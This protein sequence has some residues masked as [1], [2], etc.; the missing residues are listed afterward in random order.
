MIMRLLLLYVPVFLLLVVGCT[1]KAP[2]DTHKA[3][4]VWLS[5][6]PTFTFELFKDTLTRKW[7]IVYQ[8]NHLSDTI[9]TDFNRGYQFLDTA[10][11][12]GEG[13]PEYMA[14]RDSI[15]SGGGY[16]QQGMWYYHELHRFVDVWSLD[17][18]K[19]LVS[20]EKKRL[21]HFDHDYDWERN[22]SFLRD[23]ERNEPL[24]SRFY[25]YDIDFKF[26]AVVIKNLKKGKD[27]EDDS[28]FEEGVY[29]FRNGRLQ[30]I[31]ELSTKRTEER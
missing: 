16:N 13:L 31:D 12:D 27:M 22:G 24:S 23:G 19:L 6:K 1:H 9:H 26:G 10:N 30:K 18:K 25:E 7:Q 28:D 4:D 20:L 15:I 3:S 5:E 8:M 17:K 11:V 14:I 21:Y 29:V 2:L